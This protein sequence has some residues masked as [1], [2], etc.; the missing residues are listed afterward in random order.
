[1]KNIRTLLTIHPG[2]TLVDFYLL[3]HLTHPPHIVRPGLS[4]ENC[5]RVSG[6]KLAE[7]SDQEADEHIGRNR[8]LLRLAK[9]LSELA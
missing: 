7:M 9:E 3:T 5:R 6:A 1:M 4:E 8:R 2:A